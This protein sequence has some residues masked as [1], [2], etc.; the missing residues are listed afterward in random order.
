VV[1]VAAALAAQRNDIERTAV[2]VA[3]SARHAD[4]IGMDGHTLVHACR[5]HAQTALD[6]HPGDITTAQRRGEAM[7]ID[8]LITYTLETLA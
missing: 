7:T 3:G 2:L 8:E 5:V 6:A 4:R 1:F